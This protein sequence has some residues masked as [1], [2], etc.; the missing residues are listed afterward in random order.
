MATHIIPQEFADE[1]YALEPSRFENLDGPTILLQGENSPEHLKAGT[2][3]V[4]AALPNSIR[5]FFLHSSY[6]LLLS[7]CS[8]TRLSVP[9]EK[10]Y[11]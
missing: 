2:E 11:V 7:P 9:G 5:R 4:H 1:D 3:A 8:R 10:T 6:F